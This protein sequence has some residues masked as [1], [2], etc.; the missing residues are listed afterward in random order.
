VPSRE[1]RNKEV[2]KRNHTRAIDHR[3]SMQ[4]MGTGYGLLTT[5][6]PYDSKEAET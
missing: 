6:D 4:Y 2:K 1:R 5:D 3:H